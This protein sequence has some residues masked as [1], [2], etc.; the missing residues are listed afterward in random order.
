L[1]L[2]VRKAL[3][4]ALA[5]LLCVVLAICNPPFNYRTTNLVL[6]PLT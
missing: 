4:A 6:Q 5:A 1:L 3:E 2:E